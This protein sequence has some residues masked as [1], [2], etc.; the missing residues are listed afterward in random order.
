[1]ND[2][3]LTDEELNNKVREL[4][5]EFADS[6]DEGT[7]NGEL[8]DVVN[9]MDEVVGSLPRGVIWDNDLQGQTRVANVFVVDME[10][11]VLLPVRSME[12]RYLPGGYD[13]SCGE[14]LKAGEDYENA[15]IRGLREELSIEG[16]QPREVGSFTPDQERGMFCFGKVYLIEVGDKSE[17]AKFNPDEVARLEW[18]SKEEI[19]EM[20]ESEPE[21]FKRDY[22]GI[23]RMAFG[24]EK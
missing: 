13:F 23:F 20:L 3:Q 24:L 2:I 22:E 1:M 4:A 16:E 6:G 21:K 11:K 19:L 5:V 18:R 14:N 15:A 12:K 17:A 8:Q 10:G 9:S 7:D